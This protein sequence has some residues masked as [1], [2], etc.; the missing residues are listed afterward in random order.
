MLAASAIASRRRDTGTADISTVTYSGPPITIGDP[1]PETGP[2]D[3]RASITVSGLGETITDLDL[4]IEG[5][6]SGGC[7][8]TPG[9][10]HTFDGELI[11][12]LIGPDDTVVRL[13]TNRGAGGDNF[14][15]TVFDDEAAT[16]IAAGI[17]P[18]NGSYIPDGASG[19]AAFDGKAPNGTW[20]LQVLDTFP[21]DGGTINSFSLIFDATP[22][23]D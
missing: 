18:F 12:N 13:A 21:Q 20:T 7:S 9:I 11:I 8:A 3:A 23:T 2:F 15:G 4:R 1:D 10:R 22:P 14:C 6:A 5:A 17:A 19:L 16:P